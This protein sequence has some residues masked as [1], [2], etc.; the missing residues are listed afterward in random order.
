VGQVARSSEADVNVVGL[1]GERG[2]EVREFLEKNLGEGGL[3]KSV[4]VVATSD[5][6]ALRRIKGAFVATAIAEYFRDQGL[7]VMLF[8]D[9]VTRFAYAQRELGLSIGEPPATRGYTPSVFAALPRLMERA[10]NAQRGSITAF[11]TVLVEGDDLDEPVSDAARAILDG[12]IVLNRELTTRGHYPA[13]DI[14]QSLS[15]VMPD[16]VTA[17]HYRAAMAV[18]RLYSAYRGSEDLIR[19]GAYERGT[20]AEL[21]LAISKIEAIEAFLRQGA[22]ERAAFGE[23]LKRLLGELA[24][25]LPAL[26]GDVARAS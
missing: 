11:Y 17:E 9:S 7:D 8:L 16:V 3:A 18:R 13:V 25:D 26:S 14:L 20:S 5:D 6:L 21:D 23:T 12:H 19:L 10:G 1:I 15:R 2:R 4:V 22:T 24:G